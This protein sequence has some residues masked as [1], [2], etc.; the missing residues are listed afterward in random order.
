MSTTKNIA[1]GLGIVSGALLATWLFTGSRKKKT[2]E[3]LSRKSE[4][5]KKSFNA[6]K[7]KADD[8]DIHYI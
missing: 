2:Q 6:G 7:R 3:F 5:L 8:S 4:D 1:I